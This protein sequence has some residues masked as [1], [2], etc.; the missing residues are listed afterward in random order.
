MD[1]DVLCSDAE[2]SLRYIHSKFDSYTAI[3]DRDQQACDDL[4]ASIR[5][6]SELESNMDF[7]RVN[8]LNY[9]EQEALKTYEEN[10]TCKL[11]QGSVSSLP[12]A[13]LGLF[14]MFQN[15]FQLHREL[16][17]RQILLH[18]RQIAQSFQYRPQLLPNIEKL[19][20]VTSLSDP[21]HPMRL[22][23]PASTVSLSAPGT[24]IGLNNRA[25]IDAF[26]QVN[27]SAAFVRPTIES[28]E[29][30]LTQLIRDT[31]SSHGWGSFR[32]HFSTTPSLLPDQRHSNFP[33]YR[34]FIIENRFHQPKIR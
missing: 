17:F 7:E 30:D 13:A 29:I 1:D 22:T 23:T 27:E 28:N 16:P 2:V 24:S 15:L 6:E 18:E 9:F 4:I 26:H 12:C 32:S 5:D 8:Q 25:E 19:R 11:V 21:T 3:L 33:M 34:K 14:Q 31:Y 20:C 10:K